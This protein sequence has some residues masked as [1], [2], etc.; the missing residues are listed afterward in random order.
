MLSDFGLTLE[1]A[2]MNEITEKATAHVIDDMFAV[3]GSIPVK[4]KK[5]KEYKISDPNS[6]L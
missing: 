4:M 5:G 1:D 6:D 3:Q 2:G